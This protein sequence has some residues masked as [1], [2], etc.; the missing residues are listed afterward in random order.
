MITFLV[1]LLTYPLIGL[2]LYGLTFDKG[3]KNFKL[4]H[5]NANDEE[6]LIT[7]FLVLMVFTVS[8][9]ALVV[10]SFGRRVSNFF[11]KG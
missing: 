11:N 7:F 10:V 9:P 8:W 5:P 1:M 4:K 6:K 2:F 3:Y